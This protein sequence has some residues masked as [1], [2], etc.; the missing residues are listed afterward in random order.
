VTFAALT[1]SI[2]LQSNEATKSI[3]A[4]ASTTGGIT[5]TAAAH[6]YSN[7][8]FGRLAGTTDYNG[9]FIVSNVTTNTFDIVN[10]GLTF[11]TSQTGTFARG[12]KNP[13]GAN[14]VNGA[15][16]TTVGGWALTNI[17]GQ[18]LLITGSLLID[19]TTDCLVCSLG[20]AGVQIGFAVGF[21]GTLFLGAPRVAEDDFEW[22]TPGVAYI[23]TA[24]PSLFTFPGLVQPDGCLYALIG[25]LRW[26]R[27]AVVARTD[28][29]ANGLSIAASMDV[30]II[31]GVFLS[32]RGSAPAG[33]E[34]LS[35]FDTA[36]LS[37]QGFDMVGGELLFRPNSQSG[38]IT[39]LRRTASASA[40]LPLGN[41]T[42]TITD[43]EIGARG[44][45]VD[46]SV[47][48]AL[49]SLSTTR[50]VN[51]A[52]GNNL[53][54]IGGDAA[55]SSLNFGLARVIK[56][57]RVLAVDIDANEIEAAEVFVRDFN[58]GQRKNLNS[59]DDTADK[60][61]SDATDSSGLT[62][63]LEVET[64]IV[65]VPPGTNA[66]GT[67]NVGLYRIDFRGKN[68]ST[69]SAPNIPDSTAEF[70]FIVKSYLHLPAVVTAVL[71]GTGVQV[72]RAV[73]VDDNAVTSDAV[74]ASKWT[75]FENGERVYDVAKLYS[76]TAGNL[77]YPS[78][79]GLVVTA[80]ASV[81]DFGAQLVQLVTGVGTFEVTQ[82][83]QTVTIDT[84]STFTPTPG[85]F[86]TIRTTS[87]TRIINTITVDG[88]TFDCDV[89]LATVQDLEDVVVTGQL[90]IA[91]AGTYNFTGGS[92]A[93]VANGSAGN[94]TIN[95]RGGATI[96]TNSGPNITILSFATITL[97]GLR[98]GSEV[99]AYQGSL[100]NAS[101]AVEIG[102]VE[103][104]GT[105]FSF[106][107]SSGGLAGYIVIH[108]EDFENLVIDFPVVNGGLPTSDVT[109]PVNQTF[110]RN[111]RNP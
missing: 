68:D 62:S 51:A 56:Q 26:Q 19:P 50:V 65:N 77:E 86:S 66:R 107:Q 82:G 75:T 42:F 39:G 28:T 106:E 101:A 10:Q 43:P 61:Y 110:D 111:F 84:S 20:V 15:T 108:R 99:R 85:G 93:D 104:S 46:V 69:A 64:A 40:L 78:N 48:T 16:V 92:I 89:Q 33:R 87:E 81:L 74:T 90:T 53:K 7:G 47:N 17:G 36:S 45:I 13:R 102:G 59:V 54:M 24:N 3:T 29:T 34:I 9:D 27:C 67:S 72:V 21:E 55:A 37:I 5:V 97:V 49:V 6:G 79:E 73:L 58:N 71:T 18:Q 60:T 14:G 2:I 80:L 109:I 52:A 30:E 100:A 91:T 41:T 63:T 94:V 38:T 96:G 32:G 1:G 23:N 83:S 35:G 88:W 31:D 95:L 57:V 44:N 105:S 22:S 12:D 70:D 4:I 98:T 25:K 76:V 11:T 103:S 8:D